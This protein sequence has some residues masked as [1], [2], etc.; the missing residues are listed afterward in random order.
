MS[1]R[2]YQPIQLVNH[3]CT[4]PIMKLKLSYLVSVCLLMG[5]CSGGTS[6]NVSSAGTS[7]SPTTALK[8]DPANDPLIIYGNT[9][10]L[11]CVTAYSTV[12]CFKP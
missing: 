12:N 6:G 5:S 4:L 11:P 1:S 7:T 8:Y 2:F 9:K 3:Y 10:L